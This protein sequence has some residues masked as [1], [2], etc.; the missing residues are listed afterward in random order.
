M[1]T[2]TTTTTTLAPSDTLLTLEDVC[3]LLR[4]YGVTLKPVEIAVY[5]RAVVHRSYTTRGRQNLLQGNAACPADRV[6]LQER[7]NE[8][9][10]FLGDAVLSL[11]VAKYLFDR[12]PDQDEGFL[13][14]M[15]SKLVNG[16][17]LADLAHRIGLDRFVLASRSVEGRMPVFEDLFEAF[18]GA[19]FVDFN[20]KRVVGSSGTNDA[21]SGLGF[22]VAE[23]WVTGVLDACI[24]FATIVQARTTPKELL[25]THCLRTARG[26]PAWRVSDTPKGFQAVVRDA[27]GRTLGTGTGKS[28]KAA[29]FAASSAALRY[30]GVATPA[31]HQSDAPISSFRSV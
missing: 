19:I 17:S 1:N 3:Q 21:L 27:E 2:T 23:R 26:R 13:T 16:R 30:L 8:R 20:R 7:S 12:Y 29:E 24:D 28:R 9:L 4:T 15:R 14:Q 25:I 31:S 6:P 5:R 11:I 22:Q 18:V 10:E